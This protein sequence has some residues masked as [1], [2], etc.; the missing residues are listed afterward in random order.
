VPAGVPLMADVDDLL[1]AANRGDRNARAELFELLYADLKRLAHARLRAGR[2]HG[3][4]D[5]TA[6]VHESY[7]KLA[8]RG[9]V[10][11]RNRGAFFSY[12]GKVMRNVVLDLF[13]ERG[14]RK[15]GGEIKIVTLTTGVEGDAID[16]A[17]LLAIDDA[18]EA[19]ARIAPDLHAIV[20]MR[21]FAGLSIAEISEVTGRS[22]RSI[23]REWEKARAFLHQ[24]MVEQ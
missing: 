6:L 2:P 9:A 17:R 1:F 16:E 21:Y 15:R 10:A 8:E 3:G 18:M 14:A 7:I 4:F 12:I 23:E 20:E 22:V 24:L 11:P 19:L 5:T 13:R